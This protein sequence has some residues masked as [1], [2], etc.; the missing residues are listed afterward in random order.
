MVIELAFEIRFIQK[1]GINVFYV[2]LLVL[3]PTCYSG[4]E[5]SLTLNHSQRPADALHPPKRE[6][7]MARD[8]S[9]LHN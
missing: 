4:L 1:T 5:Q 2:I 3:T 7:S 6:F 9:V 8:H